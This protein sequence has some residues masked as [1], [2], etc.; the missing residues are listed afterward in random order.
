MADR[1]DQALGFH[2]TVLN[3]R[4]QRQQVLA[5]NI[6]NADTPNFKARDIDFRSALAAATGARSG[7]L[8]LETTSAAHLARGPGGAHGAPAQYRTELQARADGNTVD[9][10]VERA[11]FAENALQYEASLTFINGVLRSMQT[12]IT[13]Q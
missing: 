8:A 10:D 1:I 6:A 13:G 5:A 4:A 2:H 11:Q 9:L 12:A 7:A 3:L